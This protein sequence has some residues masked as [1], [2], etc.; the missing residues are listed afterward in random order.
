[1]MVKMDLKRLF[2]SSSCWF[3]Y[4][5]TYNNSYGFFG[6]QNFIHLGIKAFNEGK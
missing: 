2:R 1:M 6:R 3:N 5:N 4:V